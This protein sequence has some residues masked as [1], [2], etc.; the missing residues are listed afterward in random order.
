[1]HDEGEVPTLAG[2]E[3]R[4]P[5]DL[6]NPDN[7]GYDVRY[8]PQTGGVVVYRRIGGMNVRMPYSMT[9]EDYNND[10]VRRSMIDYWMSQEQQASALGHMKDVG[11]AG[12]KQKN[13]ILNAKWEIKSAMFESI[14]GSNQ[15]SMKLAGQAQISL[16]IQYHKID[17]PTLQ[18]KMRKSTSF[19]FDQSVQINLDAQV[20]EKLHLGINY[21]TQATFDFENEVKLEYN[22]NEDDIIQN[23][24]AG[25]VNWSLPGTLIQGSQSLFGFK[26]D[27]KFG[28]LSV[29]GVFSQKKGESQTMTVQNG[30]TKQEFDIDI[31]EYQKNQHFFLNHTFK[32]NYDRALAKL[33][34]INS[35]ITINRIEVWVTNKSGNYTDARNILAFTDLGET[36]G[37][38]SNTGMWQGRPGAVPSNEANNLYSAMSEGY[39]SARDPNTATQ[40]VLSISGMRT[41]RDFEKVENARMLTSS[42]YTLN[43]H[44]GYIS[45]S[46]PLNNNEVLAV[47]YQYTYRGQTYTV[48]ELSTQG[49]NAPKCLYLKMLKGTSLTPSYKN[50]DLMMKNIYSLGNFEIESEDFELNVVYCNDSTSSYLNYF[51][52]GPVPVNGGRNGQ[53][54]LQILNLDRLNGYQQVSA[55]GKYDYVEGVTINSRKGLIIFPEREPFGEYLR[56]KLKATPQTAERLAFTALYDSTQVFAKQQTK[57][58][59]FK[60]RGSYQSQNSS[61]ISLNAFNIAPGSVKLTAGGQVLQENVDY[62]VDYS[63]GRV[64]ILNAGLLSSGTPIQIAYENEATVSMQTQT[65]VGAHLDYEF[66]PDF[67]VGGTVLHMRER[68]L[69][70]K[71]AYGEE[72]ISNTMLGLNLD[73]AKDLPAI[74]R[75][76]DALPMISTKAKSSVS[77]EAE[78]AKLIAGH[79][80]SINA[81]YIDDFEGSSVKYDIK[82]WSGW[83]LAS[84]PVGSGALNPDNHSLNDLAAGYDRSKVAWYTIDP[85]FLRSMSNTP[86]HIKYD[87]EQK[88]NH[89]VREVYEDELYPNREASYGESTNISTLNLMF[90]PEER[91]PYNFTTDLDARGHLAN[92]TQSWAGIQRKLETTDF[93]QQN[94]EYIEFWLMDPFIYRQDIGGDFYF[95]VGNVSED[96][97]PDSRKSYEHGLPVPG[98]TFDVDSTVWG[99]VP[100][101]NSLINGFNTDAASMRAQDVGLNGMNSE[102]ERYYY[103]KPGIGFLDKLA[104]M[105]NAGALTDSAYQVM[106]DDP[107]GDD[108]HYYRGADYDQDEVS[109]T[110]RYKRFNGMEGNS[111]PSEYSPET[112]TTASTNQPDN[113]DLNEDYTLN[114]NE[115]Y[116][117]YHL[118]IR[119]EA[120][121][122]GENY[123]A[124]MMETSKKLDNG[125]TET[126]KW[127]QFKIPL[128]QPDKVVGDMSD[129]SSMQFIRMAMTNFDVSPGAAESNVI[130]RF[131][132]LDLVRGEWRKYTEA[133]VEPDGHQSGATTFSTNSV[134]IEENDRRTPVNYVLP[135]GVDRVVDPSNPQLRQLNEQAYS[136]K[137][138]D[139]ANGDAR[140]VYKTLNMDFRN[141]RRLRM[142]IHCETPEGQAALEDNQVSAFVRLGSDYEDNYYEYEIPLKVTPAGWYTSNN[143]GDRYVVW[144]TENELDLPFSLLSECK[145]KRNEAKR[146]YGSNMT[147]QDVYTMTDPDNNKNRVRIKGNPSTGNVVVMMLGVRAHGAGTKSAEV[148]FNELR[149]TDFNERG[150][151]AARGRGTL[152]LADVASVQLSGQYSSVGFGGIDQSVLERAL[153]ENK[154]FDVSVNLDLGKFM[155]PKAPLSVP[156]FASY[157]KSTTTPLYSPYDSDVKMSTVLAQATSKHEEDSLKAISQTTEQIRSV[158]LTNLRAKPKPGKKTTMLSGTNWSASYALT[159][160]VKT[161]PETEY[162]KLRQHNGSLAYNFTAGGK[163][164]EPFKKT[165]L[166]PKYFSIIKDFTVYAW[167]SLFGYR[168]D[169]VRD[170]QEIQ[171]RNITNPEYKVPVSV[172]KSF[173]WNRYFDFR[174]NITRNLKFGFSGQTN[175]RIEEPEGPVNKH[176]YKEEFAHWKD[177]VLTNIGKF[178]KADHYSHNVDI[179]WTVP[180]NKLP[181]LQFLSAN[182]SYKGTYDWQRGTENEGFDWGNVINNTNNEQANGMVNFGTLYNKSAYL[183]DLYNRTNLS[184]SNRQRKSAT[185]NGSKVKTVTYQQQNLKFA[186]GTPIVIT[187]NLHTTDVNVRAFDAKGHSLKGMLKPLDAD[188]AQFI[189]TMASNNARIVL[190]GTITEK[191]EKEHRNVF[192]D[193]VM[194][195]LTSPKTASISYSKNNSTTLYG[196]MPGCHFMGTGASPDEGMRAPGFR[197]MIGL[198]DRQFAMKAYERGWLTVDSTFNEPYEMTRGEQLQ[199]RGSFEMFRALKVELSW[200]W[201]KDKAMTE[202][203][204]MNGSGLEAVQ[205]TQESGTFSMSYNTIRTAFQK[206]EKTGNLNYSVYS[207]F[208]RAR[209]PIS[210]RLA[211]ERLGVAG[212]GIEENADSERGDGGADGYGLMSQQVLIPAFLSAYADKSSGSIFTDLL[213]SIG[214]MAPNWRATFSGLNNIPSIKNAV[215]NIELSHSY[216]CKYSVGQFTT[217][218]DWQQAGDGLSYVRDI[219][220]NFVPRYDVGT[221]T[222]AE[223][224]NPFLGISATFVNNLTTSIAINKTRNLSLN[225]ANKQITETYGRDWNMNVGYR[226]DNVKLFVKKSKR[227]ESSGSNLNL[228]FGL[229]I[230]DSYTILRRIEEMKS[231]LAN[232]TKTTSIKVSADYAVNS[233]VNVQFYYDQSLAK[234][235]ISNSYP[236]NNINV[237]FSLQ[238]RLTD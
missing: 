54:Y 194:T 162:D 173:F 229:A 214:K 114:E 91:G 25:N 203:Y 5:V 123:I 68:P 49:I 159:E 79:S 98:Q 220:D 31:T 44:L 78:I 90:Y 192:K 105:R 63:L 117:Q 19:D 208:L 102:R 215:R 231:E 112:Y 219:D 85:L 48:G 170:Y 200:Q 193:I 67:H 189:P 42:E 141:Y 132:S 21:N 52:E 212:A 7:V 191:D 41:G 225:V 27:L 148:W 180:I 17:N 156:I 234:P 183:R 8:D 221:V 15:I 2:Q 172:T 151:W 201:Q 122:V 47:A 26:M 181:F 72:S 184:S 83:H 206:P 6:K 45:L 174:Y 20:G 121:K 202:Y 46:S 150:G 12:E 145:L 222:I 111:C 24:E 74:T 120:M 60:L 61:E 40:T 131:A 70:N 89:Y 160:T 1:M 101:T 143:E 139:L 175:A 205:G 140:A 57:K 77:I 182:A 51:N 135:P 96:V 223:Q 81:A 230:R 59:K 179:Q 113:E 149:L 66:N 100:S 177:S 65:L 198:Q 130:M 53:T 165:N 94:I 16:G 97:L 22:G 32:E 235:Y 190:T 164:V 146:A 104:Q 71:V 124:D 171:K 13:T 133:L 109:I 209:R 154:Q 224:F 23:I 38:I 204:I 39:S 106:Y 50:W 10:A 125:N 29:S 238:L 35:G 58:N 236:T 43:E 28:K 64:K 129:M 119:P 126:I 169:V 144:P 186:V 153:D 69:T 99:Y 108:F 226:F 95:Q 167:P 187:H 188:R 3:R 18:E 37:N 118:N 155:G 73:Y 134:N 36:G 207:A 86:R 138:E 110:D 33:P 232:G 161:D 142:Y 56:E 199:I 115:S 163:P 227:G 213:P 233:L 87:R 157:S 103:N 55:D 116:Y 197:F 62:T 11:S 9:L 228:T 147:L 107:A 34:T 152:K 30:A 168:W 80:S 4:P 216:N 75:G 217:N 88:S 195:I 210:Y 137:V 128:S 185:D 14:F 84:R 196:Y 136:L 76:L 178:G 218:L 127:Y 158:N 237:G 82:A 92:P 93:E 166:N 176:K 211:G